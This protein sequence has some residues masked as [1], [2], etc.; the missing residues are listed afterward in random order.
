MDNNEKLLTALSNYLNNDD[1]AITINQINKVSKIG[2][3]E[4]RAYSLILKNYLDVDD[5]IFQEYFPLMVKKLDNNEFTSNPY[6]Q[7]I[8]F[9][10]KKCHDFELRHDMYKPYQ[11]FV[12]DDFLYLNEKVIPQIGFFNKPFYYPAVYEKNRLWMS[13]TPNEI[14]TMEKPL[15][16]AH[17]FIVTVGLGLGYYAYMASLKEEV[18]KVLVIE[19]SKDVINLFQ[20]LILPQFENKDK[21]IIKEMDVLDFL[22]HEMKNYAVDYIF[23]DIWHD[24]SDGKKWVNI[25]KKY[26]ALYPHTCFSYWI[27]DTIKYYL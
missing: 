16:E 12:R 3:S 26:E 27:M 18:S 17:G 21:I 9:K 10:N 15:R 24:A 2:I 11:A 20:D 1:C 8:R 23:F 7:N 4:E 6:Y 13:I 19:K 22:D 25:L 5:E 14:K